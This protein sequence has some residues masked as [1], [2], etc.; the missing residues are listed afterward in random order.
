MA[1]TTPS[2]IDYSKWD[3]MDYGSDSDS[4]S[5]D[6]DDASASGLPRVT[7]LDAPSTIQTS[8]KDGSIS[9][10]SSASPS[11]QRCQKKE[12]DDDDDDV[13]DDSIR[14]SKKIEFVNSTSST[15]K[16][17]GTF[18][19]S[20]LV[21]LTQNGGQWIDPITHSPLFWSQ[22]RHEVIFNIAFDPSTCIVKDIKL[23]VEGAVPYSQRFSAVGTG[24][25]DEGCGSM[26]VEATNGK[27]LLKGQ[28][29]HFVH[30]PE[31]E[32]QLDWEVID[33]FEEYPGQPIDFSIIKEFSCKK[34][35]RITM[36][37]AVP[38]VGVTMW[39]SQ[40]LSHFPKIDVNSIE[41]RRTSDRQDK[42]KNVWDEAHSIF[43]QK[44]ANGDLE[45]RPI[46]VPDK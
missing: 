30:F 29:P 20:V 15:D 19:M 14:T 37:K 36:M 22:N 17:D 6:I 33:P 24:A 8:A 1:S 39:W 3:R 7:K 10:V 13:V 31:D 44:V 2:G 45:Q 43:Q 21:I 11:S 9:I 18:K 4:D 28:L 27:I 34:L 5:N 41:G 23:K 26:V 40:P 38:M 25:G 42:L 16:S 46:H 32:E 35:L 12:G